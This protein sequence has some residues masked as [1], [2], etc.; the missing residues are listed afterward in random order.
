MIENMLFRFR[1]MALPFQTLLIGAVFFTIYDL[2]TYFG[3]GLGAIESGIE[4]LLA[5]LIFMTA[6]YF[7][8]VALRSRSSERRG[9]GLRKKR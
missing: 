4:A 9:K 5:S 1:A 8:S 6:Y 3:H 7:T 2:Y